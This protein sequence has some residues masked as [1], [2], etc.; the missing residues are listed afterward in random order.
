MTAKTTEANMLERFNALYLRLGESEC[1]PWTGMRGSDGYPRMKIDNKSRRASHVSMYLHDGHWPMRGFQVCHHCDNPKCVN[2]KHLYLGT[3]D[4]NHRDK[5]KRKRA[6][7]RG[8][9]LPK[10]R[11]KWPEMLRRH[12]AGETLAALAADYGVTIEAVK[13][14]IRKRKKAAA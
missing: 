10:L 8:C 13:Y 12:D 3:H 7:G 1:W 5:M 14:H 2:P 9:G 11:G 4:E 6:V